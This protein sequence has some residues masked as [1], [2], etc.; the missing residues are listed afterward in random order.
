MPRMK[1]HATLSVLLLTI[2]LGASSTAAR[3]QNIDPANDGSQYAWGENVGWINFQPSFGPGVS[4]TDSAMAGLAWGENIGWI[5]LSPTA[6]GV[7]NDGAGHLSGYAWGENIGWINFAPTGG[8]VSINACGEF[9]GT[10]YGENIGWISFRSSTAFPFRV[11][12]SWVPSNDGTPPVTSA[13]GAG[14]GWSKTDVSVTLSAT[15]CG[16]GTGEIHYTLDTNPEVVI[17]GSSVSLNIT[18]EGIHSL[19]YFSVDAAGNREAANVL[20]VRIDKTAP[21]IT[22]MSPA[23]GATY[24]INQSVAADFVATDPVSGLASLISSGV[25]G[26]PI[27]TSTLGTR[28]FSVTAVDQAGNSASV[29]HT[30]SVI[31]PAPPPQSLASGYHHTLALASDRTLWAWGSNS[32]GQLGVFPGAQNPSPQSCVG[33]TNTCSPLPFQVHG[34]SN[35]I[36]LA[37]GAAHS[38]ALTQDGRVWAWG[39]N[40]VGQL[41]DGTTQDR[42]TAVQ[43]IDPVGGGFLRNVVAIAAGG[44]HTLALKDDGTVWTW[45][46]NNRS[47]LG[48]GV[49]DG[50]EACGSAPCRTTPAR[51]SL[52]GGSG[53]LS[54]IVAIAGGLQHSVAVASD[55]TAWTWG[56]NNTGQLGRASNEI[57]DGVFCGST[58]APVSGPSGIGTL[59]GIVAVAAGESHSIALNGDGTVWTWG[60][61]NFGQLG[62]GSATGPEL[63]GL[64]P[65]SKSALQVEGGLS[66]VTAV[67]AGA[68]HSIALKADGTLWSWGWNDS[69]QLAFRGVNSH[70]GEGMGPGVCGINLDGLANCSGLPVQ[71]FGPGG[72]GVL[73]GVVAVAAGNIHTVALRDD[74]T[75]WAWGNRSLFRQTGDGSNPSPP[76]R[77]EPG[78]VGVVSLRVIPVS[79]SIAVGQTQQFT[80]TA[81]LP[82]DFTDNITHLV[83]WSSSNPGVAPIDIVVQGDVRKGL[84]A[85]MSLGA[86]TITARSFNHI[87]STTLSVGVVNH[88]PVAH[89]GPDQVV[90]AANA[91][92]AN[93]TLDGSASFDPDGD[94]LTFNW[95]GPFG[96][97][98]GPNPIVALPIGTSTVSLAVSDGQMIAIDE[99]LITVRALPVTLTSIAVTPADSTIAVEQTQ[100]FTATGTFSD[101]STRVLATGGVSRPL[102]LAGWWPGD[103]QANDIV[104]GQH[105]ILAGG[106]TFAPGIVGQAFA[107]DG[108]DDRVD[109]PFSGSNN[110]AGGITTDAWV[111][112]NAIKLGSR[113]VGR[114]LSPSSCSYPYLSFDLD[115]R[116]QAGN[117]AVFYFSTSDD[118]LYQVTGTSVI[119]TG[120]FTHLAATYDGS[121]ARLYV[122]GVLESSLAVSGTLKASLEPLVVGNAGEACRPPFVGQVEFDGLIDEVELYGRALDAPE[123]QAIFSAGSAERCQSLSGCVEWSSSTAAAAIDANGVATGQSPGVTT[124]AATSTAKSAISGGTTLTVVNPNQAPI[125]NAGPD[126]IVEAPGAAGASITLDGSASFDPDGD[127]LTFSWTGPFGAAS[128]ANPTV[129]L[130]VGTSIVSL[131]VDDGDLTDTDTVVITVAFVSLD[132][133]VDETTPQSVLDTITN[134]PGCVRMVGTTRPT[135]VMPNLESIG[136]CVLVAD[137]PPLTAVD[138]SVTQ[139]I[140]GDIEFRGNTSAS[141]IDLRV[142]A[143]I[144]GNLLF[145]GNGNTTV[146]IETPRVDGSVTI[147]GTTGRS[148]T[149]RRTQSLCPRSTR[150]AEI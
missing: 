113:V 24:F 138:I 12:T 147:S 124:I 64:D 60:Q 41:G 132:V 97:A 130:P 63:C 139:R 1:C 116:A 8:G 37:G 55:G 149:V 123:I 131:T 74:G 46:W 68:R 129:T 45:G 107:F 65:C 62:D 92:G 133:I 125:A 142:G 35:V 122:N 38:V 143:G 50:P 19:T 49:A 7:V 118:V 77:L 20:S 17:Q 30:Y 75:L 58:A 119:P 90:D 52:G 121:V 99:V 135:L 53:F 23:D 61:N 3:A 51:V 150:S 13:T 94:A 40:G 111:K 73:N 32:N 10:A 16:S 137:N 84:T 28:I 2:L 5:N 25:N 81:S 103:G 43:V 89:A 88:A 110:F 108:V 85:G 18:A 70:V 95:T 39:S 79:P 14:S 59:G 33:S 36:A 127:A 100:G 21:I 109:I 57:C 27:A 9:S 96:T 141:T 146:T 128:G 82:D 126:R 66:G 11:T 144:G 72:V 67:A 140:G 115:V 44:Y 106:V 101:G 136:N 98:S 148:R 42:Y 47:Q 6:G 134:V 86:T 83:T 69:G 87:V 78:P 76:Y 104:G 48:A 112:P 145:D 4:V 26:S 114:E 91:S 56:V 54:G 93:L 102:G 117:R 71:A 31:L 15:D 34:L 105:G 22:L 120:V 80:A 29:T